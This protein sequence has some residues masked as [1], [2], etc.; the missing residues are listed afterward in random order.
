MRGSVNASI[1]GEGCQYTDPAGRVAVLWSGRIAFGSAL[2][3]EETGRRILQLYAEHG[4]QFP[5]H[6]PGRFALA[7]HD[8]DHQRTLLARDAAGLEPLYYASVSDGRLIFGSTICDVLPELGLV[9]L[10]PAA[11]LDYLAFFWSLDDKTFFQGVHLLPQGTVYCNGRTER[12]SEF[13]PAPEERSVAEWSE[14]IL[15]ALTNATNAVRSEAMGC[16]LSG[17]IDSSLLTVLLGQDRAVPP[18]AFVAAF[19]EYPDHDEARFGRIVARRLGVELVEIAP[20]PS[21]LPE[22]F[23]DMI[24]TIEEPKCHPPVFPRFLLETTAAGRGLRTMVGGRGADELFTGY[25]WHRDA[26]LAR[27]REVRTVFNAEQRARLLRPEFLAEVDY[28]P[29]AAYEQVLEDCPSST[30]LEKILALDFRTLLANW[31]VL[32]YKISRRFGIQPAAPFLDR[33][34]IELALRIP[35]ELK[36][37]NGEPKGLLKSAVV[38]LLPAEVLD[39]RKVGFRTPFG[40]MLRAGLENFVRESL[41]EDSSAFWSVFNPEGVSQLVKDHFRGDSNQGWQIWAVLC[42]REW[43]RQF[44]DGKEGP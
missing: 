11:L 40:E 3:D 15:E 17:G 25:E 34:V 27:H 6:L 42:I 16:H 13:E 39:R 1:Q 12:Y 29:E 23:S 9:T 21:E 10:N 4:L 18:P 36:R 19:P 20:K 8:S 43:F 7:L 31:L 26:A 44:L 33:R 2:S 32:D 35:A 30:P 28:G 22:V 37:L 24:R 41:H 5:K 14:A 38:H